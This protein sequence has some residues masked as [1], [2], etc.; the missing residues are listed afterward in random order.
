MKKIKLS[1]V[2]AMLVSYAY[3]QNTNFGTSSGTLGTN[4]SNFGYFAGNSN[5]G[6]SADN[7]YF[8]AHSGRLTTS[9]NRNV[10]VGSLALFYN[11]SGFQNTAVGYQA[12]HLA[13]TNSLNSAFGYRALYSATTH[14]NA[15]F[16]WSALELNTIGFNNSAFGYSALKATTTGISNAGVG[17]NALYG[18]TTG[19]H[20]TAVG[21]SS[22]VSNQTGSYNSGFGTA[23]G[24]QTSNLDNTTC[25]GYNAFATAS[26]QVRL[27]NASVF[28]I[29]GQVAWSV[30]SDQRFKSNVKQNIPGLEFINQLNPVSYDLNRK[31][32]SKFLGIAD[33]TIQ[34]TNH[35]SIRQAGF[36]AQE[37]EAAVK[38]G[39]YEFY[40]VEAP[41]NE[42]DHYSIRY[43]DFVMPLVKAVQELS[44]KVNDQQQM[45][46]NQAAKI[47]SLLTTKTPDGQRANEFS[48]SKTS[49]F[50]NSPNPSSTDT[51]IKMELSSETRQATL[52]IY[53]MEGTQLKSIE[54]GER[55]ASSVKVSAGELKPGLYLYALIA[56]GKVIDVK[57]MVLTN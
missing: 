2:L 57:R 23:S 24:P 16:G 5:N 47:D 30:L 40:G 56:D 9:G 15:A 55:G 44:A 26:N 22:V 25:L 10:A 17:Y 41:Q 11:S 39:N 14:Y 49:L 46:E 45:L 35:E 52:I 38:K 50:Q 6:S 29:G 7:A 4:N 43:S 20:N 48:N 18:N 3:A 37:V 32:F 19:S 28:S 34:K 21:A 31:A 8:G 54:V 51:E 33:S 36:I 53:N 13:T 1:I 12:L 42:R 27:G